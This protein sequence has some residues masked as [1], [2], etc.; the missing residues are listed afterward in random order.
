MNRRH[1]IDWLRVIAIILVLYFHTAMIFV[2][3]W[4]WHIK[5]EE[6]SYLWL[7]FNFFLSSFRMPLLFFISGVGSYF[8]LRKRTGWQYV[9]ERHNRL[10]IPVVFGM[11]V[12]VPPQI[13][14]ERI[15]E[16]EVFRS[17]FDFYPTVLQFVPYPAGN[18]SWHHL[19]FVVYLFIFSAVGAP[20]F[21]Y[22]KSESG[23]KL[24]NGFTWL[25]TKWGVY[26][27]MVPTALCYVTLCVWFPRSNDLIHDV[28]YLVYWFSFF[29]AGYLVE[30]YSRIWDR[31]EQNRK[32]SLMMGVLAILIINVIRWN[33][34][35]LYTEDP[36]ALEAFYL[37]AFRALYPACGWLWLLTALGYGRKYLNRPTKF[38][39]YA[40]RAIYPFYILHQTLIIVIGY[41]VIQVN[42][43][44]LSKFLFI[45]TLS[46]LLS[47]AIY[48]FLI[49]P[50]RVT[51]FLFG[52]KE[53][54]RKAAHDQ[55][56]V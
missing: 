44:I 48:D 13:Y 20:I 16:G 26:L 50:F 52:V 12:I 45:S 37:T 54:R 8:A 23:R 3:E 56:T 31:I 53:Q 33:K 46:L 35:E 49:R 40:N 4:D 42:E 2:E 29:L 11:L 55:T 18:F 36:S 24:F 21:V 28:G 47:V 7:E 9:G 27:L 6:K 32:F 43:S 51:R 39:A 25:S 30:C 14:F 34:I 22:L 41:Y 17:F 1:D 19:W 5:N 38:L 15:F 10:L